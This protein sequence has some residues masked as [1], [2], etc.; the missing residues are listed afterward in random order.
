MSHDH[1][2][3]LVR[4]L[5]PIKPVSPGFIRPSLFA[6]MDDDNTVDGDMQR[7][8]ILSTLESARRPV[9]GAPSKMRGDRR[10]GSAF[11]L[12]SKVLVALMGM[13]VLALLASFI[14]VVLNGHAA[15]PRLDAAMQARINMTDGTTAAQS[16]GSK[17]GAARR[18]EVS[19]NPLAALIAPPAA[20]PAAP[21]PATPVTAQAE[22]QAAVIETVLIPSDASSVVAPPGAPA[23]TPATFALVPPV[24]SALPAL[25]KT[26]TT[27]AVKA[28]AA[29]QT[30]ATAKPAQQTRRTQQAQPRRDDDVALLE[31]MFTHASSARKST[32]SAAEELQRRCSKLSGAEAATCRASVC[33]QNPSAS[34][35]HQD[36]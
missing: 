26:A 34:V 32:A 30:V 20:T 10:R 8:R 2:R 22:P 15:S 33:V 18:V 6:G 23:V 19:N 35:C 24:P 1:G 27:R 17:T 25:D 12:S 36:P 28:L 29:E 16:T 3:Q 11:S 31:A 7:V 14:I 9:R 5:S 4:H 13:G 21:P